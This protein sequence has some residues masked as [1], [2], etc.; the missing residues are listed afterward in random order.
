MNRPL[1]FVALLLFSC[2][3]AEKR[4]QIT[5]A[6]I[7]FTHSMVALRTG[8]YFEPGLSSAEQSELERDYQKA[9]RNLTAAFGS[10]RGAPPLTLF[11]H[12]AACKV[13]FGSD[14]DVAASSIGFARDGVQTSSGFVERSTVIVTGPVTFTDR[15][16]THELVHAEMKAWLPYDALP[17]WFNEGVA[18][19]L[20]GEPNCGEYA[21][22][23]S[24]GIEQLDTKQKW[25]AHISTGNTLRTYCQARDR[26]E[27]WAISLGDARAFT[28]EL[29][30]LMHAVAAGESLKHAFAEHHHR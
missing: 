12:T 4:R 29:R 17:T 21:A 15:I 25:Q 18:T 3:S 6:P 7:Q 2:K 5:E 26:I 1:V 22:M 13:A 16:L 19:Y 9:Q 30:N 11:C 8:V 28:S 10:L 23:S 27:S 24:L 20:A 14:P